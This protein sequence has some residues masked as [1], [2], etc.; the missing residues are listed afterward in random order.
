MLKTIYFAQKVA[1][2][3]NLESLYTRELK[4]LVTKVYRDIL[5]NLNRIK[6]NYNNEIRKDDFNDDFNSF[7][8]YC[9]FQ[10]SIRI[11]GFIPRITK[12]IL[13]ANKFNDKAVTSSLRYIPRS[14]M[15]VTT[16]KEIRS[17]MELIVS[18]NVRLIK[19]INENLL[20]QVQ[21]VIYSGVRRGVEISVLAD[22]LQ[23]KFTLSKKRATLIARDQIQKA[24]SDLTRLRHREIGIKEYKWVTGRDERVRPSHR[25]LESKICSYDDVNVYKNNVEDKTW[26]QKSEIGGSLYHPGQEIQCRCTEIAIIKF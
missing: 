14:V 7:A 5:E 21:E 25:V 22:E 17:A 18:D 19:S 1:F 2:P 9:K 24:H 8:D 20:G 10:I 13:E 12:I 26:L 6:P 15:Q 16:S 3:Y 4:E 11:R 23:N